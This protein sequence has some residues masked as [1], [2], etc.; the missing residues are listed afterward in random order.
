MTLLEPFQDVART[1][2]AVD[3]IAAVRE[4]LEAAGDKP[5]LTALHHLHRFSPDELTRLVERE[6]GL[7]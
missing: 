4:R 7:P 1:L 6:V 3:V 5:A 2:H